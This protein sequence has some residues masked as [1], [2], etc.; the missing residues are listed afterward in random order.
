MTKF[1]VVIVEDELLARQRLKKLLDVYNDSIEIIGEASNGA[2]GLDLIETLHP[3]F[4]FLDIQMPV[5]NGFDMILKLSK[6]PYIIFT[7]AFDEYAIQAFE[8]NAL[9]YLLKPIRPE[10]LE[11]T[12]EKMK[13]IMKNNQGTV[14]NEDRL[15]AL[16]AKMTPEKELTNITVHSGDRIHIVNLKDIAFF[17]SEDK[18][19]VIYK[20]SNE[21]HLMTQSL[22][23]LEKKLPD[24]FIKIN[25]S[26]IINEHMIQ[27]I[28]KGFNGKF[29]FYMN[30]ANNTKLTTG[31]TYTAL[32]KERL[33]F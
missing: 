10:R 14:M 28:R 21:K 23:Q 3:D 12:I 4:I 8:E 15:R 2:Q 32:I 7:T 1:K 9:D 24:H 29:V 16:L 26:C 6:Q 25:R 18:M 27:E 33:K 17:R 11:V 5:M 20:S 13:G 22:T 30:D 19:T 31:S